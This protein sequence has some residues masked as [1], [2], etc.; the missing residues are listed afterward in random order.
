M[1]RHEQRNRLGSGFRRVL[2]AVLEDK[3]KLQQAQL[4][5]PLA[6]DS[7]LEEGVWTMRGT[8]IWYFVKLELW[9]Q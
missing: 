1:D 4:F 6:L 8:P 5:D 3:L 2:C 9:P 7:E